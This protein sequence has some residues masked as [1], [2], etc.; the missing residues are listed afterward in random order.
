MVCGRE[1]VTF[2][3]GA[4]RVLTPAAIA[5]VPTKTRAAIVARGQA[6]GKQALASFLGGVAEMG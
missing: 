4:A 3:R 6:R 5:K 1:R 2:A